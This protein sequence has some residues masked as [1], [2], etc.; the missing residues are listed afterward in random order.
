VKG[1]GEV[2]KKSITQM[3]SQKKYYPGYADVPENINIVIEHTL[4]FADVDEIKNVISQ[5]GFETC[6][7]VWERNLLHDDRILKLNHFL[8]KFIFKV[9]EH[10]DIVNDYILKHRQKRDDR[11]GRFFNR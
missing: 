8:A 1:G 7:L 2:F 9:A 5:Y 10:E 3:N 6:R 11:I 4:R